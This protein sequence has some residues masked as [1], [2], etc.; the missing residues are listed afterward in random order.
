MKLLLFISIYAFVL[1]GLDKD[2]CVLLV[3][4][5]KDRI[6]YEDIIDIIFLDEDFEYSI[7]NCVVGSPSPEP[8]PEEEKK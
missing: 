2:N 6:E 5:D 7:Q 4:N 1:Q 3:I 8:E